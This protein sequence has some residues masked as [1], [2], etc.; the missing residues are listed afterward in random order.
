M[1]FCLREGRWPRGGFP[2][3]MCNLRAR[4]RENGANEYGGAEC[5]SIAASTRAWSRFVESN[6]IWADEWR[7]RLRVCVSPA[8]TFPHY[9]KS[10][11]RHLALAR[12]TACQPPRRLSHFVTWPPSLKARPH[13]AQSGSEIS[14]YGYGDWF[15]AS[16]VSSLV[17]WPAV[18]ATDMLFGDLLL[19]AAD[20]QKSPE[21]T[22]AVALSS[23]IPKIAASYCGAH[24]YVPGAWW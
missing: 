10:M 14:R 23:L 17:S 7:L 8:D 9:R 24:L 11:L 12:R 13:A 20:A 21:L 3:A 18:F 4:T 15:V 22:Q 1:F 6:L 19:P 16:L 2:A 5:L